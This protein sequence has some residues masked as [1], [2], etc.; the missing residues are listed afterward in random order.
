MQPPTTSLVHN[1]KQRITLEALASFIKSQTPERLGR[2][3]S[4]INI[5]FYTSRKPLEDTALLET[6]AK[7]SNRWYPFLGEQ[8]TSV[9]SATGRPL[10][11]RPRREESPDEGRRR[12]AL[13]CNEAND[14]PPPAP[15]K[16]DPICPS[17]RL[18]EDLFSSLIYLVI[19]RGNKLQALK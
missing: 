12:A 16:G 6:V 10:I 14:I 15:F 17:S 19:R 18:A 13:E 5:I 2:I 11:H 1:W 4:R 8:M 7:Y 9:Q 3:A